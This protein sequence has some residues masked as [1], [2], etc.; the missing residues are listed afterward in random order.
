MDILAQDSEGRYFNVEVQRSDEGAPAR[1][2]RFYS[3]ILD[4]HFLQPSKLYEE[5]PDT[6]VI[7]ITENDVLRDNLPLYN[8]RRRIDENAKCFEDGSHIIYV[9]SQ[10]R[11][12]TAL[13]KLMQDLYCTEPKNLH[14][15]EFAERMEFLKYSKEGEEKMTDVIEEY[16]ARKAEALAKEAAEAMA[17]EKKIEFAKDLLA[18]GMSIEFTVRLSKLSEAE[19]R[20]LASKL[21]A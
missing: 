2:A 10:R 21:S 17:K 4:T 16:A 14:Y 12:D 20:E 6:Y 11:D 15:Q 18:E 19:V 3:S 5:L 13:G 9:N 1:R 7:F 8:I